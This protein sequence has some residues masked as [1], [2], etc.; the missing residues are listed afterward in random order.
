MDLKGLILQIPNWKNQ[1]AQ[2]LFDI[3]SSLSATVEDHQLYT[4]AEIANIAGDAGATALF[5][6]LVE[7]GKN[8]AIYQLGG[9]GLDLA[10]EE[11]QQMLYYLE[12][13]GVPGMAAVALSKKRQISPLEQAGLTATVQE[14]S[15][16]LDDLLNPSVPDQHSHEVLLSANRQATGELLVV[17]TVT[18][19]GL[20]DGSVIWRGETTRYANG[21]L[22]ST[23]A[24]IMEGLI[25]G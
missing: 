7:L 11:I 5:N 8:W 1:S 16:A 3:L 6:K 12:S 15:D 25:G 23:L 18:P 2:H 4:F 14:V 17:A 24:P 10:N 21:D 20:R 9:L 19:V 13:V 22:S